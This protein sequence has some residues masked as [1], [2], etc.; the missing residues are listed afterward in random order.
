MKYNICWLSS[1]VSQ[2]S[3]VPAFLHKRNHAYPLHCNCFVLTYLLSHNIQ[4]IGPLL[5]K[6]ATSKKLKLIFYVCSAIQ[7]RIHNLVWL[8]GA[9]LATVICNSSSNTLPALFKFIVLGCPIG[10]HPV[11]LNSDA[12]L[13]SLVLFNSVIWPNH[14][15]SFSS[16]SVNRFGIP[17]PSQGIYVTCIQSITYWST[18]LEITK[19]R[20]GE[21]ANK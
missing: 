11:N 19:R 8:F 10:L 2:K 7:E 17:T 13:N 16:N 9:G 14:C 20:V 15:T 5:A 6:P 21:N 3:Y 4:D 1:Q 18:S 12:L